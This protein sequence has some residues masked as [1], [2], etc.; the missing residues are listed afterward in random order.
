[1]TRQTARN[2]DE[3]SNSDGNQPR[4]DVIMSDTGVEVSAGESNTL[5]HVGI[6]RYPVFHY[7]KFGSKGAVSE[8]LIE[9]EH[10]AKINKWSDRD[11]V[12]FYYNTLR[13]RALDM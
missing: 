6:A 13:R 11:G 12:G 7:G 9:Y 1:M 3:N 2:S 5:S 4:V 10:A 8:Y